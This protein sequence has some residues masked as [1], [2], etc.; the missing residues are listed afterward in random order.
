MVSYAWVHGLMDYPAIELEEAMETL[1][2]REFHDILPG[3]SIQPVEETSLRLMDYG[4][5]ILSRIKTRA[6]TLLP[7]ER[8]G[9]KTEKYPS[10]YTTLIPSPWKML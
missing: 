9:P 4:L 2:A 1:V 3:S 6:F 7:A 5:E 10:W 8:R